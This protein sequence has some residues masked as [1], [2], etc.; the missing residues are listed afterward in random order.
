MEFFLFWFLG[1]VAVGVWASNKGRSF[2]GWTLFSLCLS[3]L[4][5]A[6]FVAVSAKQGAAALPRDDSG[7]A[8]SPDTH[9]HCPDCRELVRNDARKCKHCQ[10]ALVPQR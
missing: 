1:A 2:F 10:T 4:L 5:G 8:V 9:V 7:N 3:P 6:I